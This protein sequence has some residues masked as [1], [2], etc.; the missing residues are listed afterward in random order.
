M[1][2]ALLL[3]RVIAQ[4]LR[5]VCRLEGDGSVLA[6]D[7][8]KHA[9]CSTCHAPCEHTTD[10]GLAASGVRIAQSSEGLCL[11]WACPG[12]GIT[13]TEQTDALRS[14]ADAA[15]VQADPLCHRC[16]QGLPA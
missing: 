1:S 7:A 3:N 11:E 10:L 12:C 4:R 5:G 15:T 13:V 6:R 9:D 2:A 16:R 8:S 14:L